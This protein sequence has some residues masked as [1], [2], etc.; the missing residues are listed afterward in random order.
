MSASATAIIAWGGIPVFSEID[1]KTYCL[2]PK[3]IEKKITKR[4]RA[5]MVVDIFGQSAD[6]DKINRI[7]KKHNLKVISDTAQSIGSKYKK[8]YSGTACDIGGFSLN[9]HKHIH[10][11]EGGVVITNNSNLAQRIYKIRNHGEVINTDKKFSNLIGF[12]YRLGE[13]ESAIAI[14]QLKKLRKIITKK[15]RFAKLLSISLKN[16][17]GLK[18]PI[19][20]KKNTHVFYSYAMQIDEKKTKHS[21]KKIFQELLKIGAPV[22]DKYVNLLDYNI[23]QK[24]NFQKYP[25]N[26]VKNKKLYSKNSLVYKQI[27]NINKKIHLDIPFC[28]YDFNKK[29]I[30]FIS[31]S[32]HQVWKKLRIK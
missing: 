3:F 25:F 29:D 31:N 23:Y 9:R 4:T 24:N 19:T 15:Q 16:L 32:F 27:L 11:G 21:K 22:N 1:I 13:I 7:A 6:Y 8:K 28:K 5:I 30:E 14:E 12:N 26:F 10:C 17:K 18:T 2:D 20:S